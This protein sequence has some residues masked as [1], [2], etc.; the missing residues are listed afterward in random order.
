MI[1]SALLVTV[2]SIDFP[3]K[4]TLCMVVLLVTLLTLLREE[5]MGLEERESNFLFLLETNAMVFVKQGEDYEMFLL[6]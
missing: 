1:E 5:E 4:L 3:E 2:V 6:C